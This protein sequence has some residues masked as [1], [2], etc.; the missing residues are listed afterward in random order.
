MRNKSMLS[1]RPSSLFLIAFCSY[2]HTHWFGDT[3]AMFLFAAGTLIIFTGMI[4]KPCLPS[5]NPQVP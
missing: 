3:L 5:W 1:L 2:K 4:R